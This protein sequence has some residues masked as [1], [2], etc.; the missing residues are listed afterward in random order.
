LQKKR[1]EEI[2]HILRDNFSLPSWANSN[3]DP[4]RTLILTVLSQATADRN[5]AQAFRNLQKR[6]TIT[7]E[8][9]SKAEIGDIENAI[10][11]GG[12]YRNKAKVI[13]AVS[14]IILN[15]HEGSLDFIYSLP[16]EDAREALLT[17]PGVGPKTA[18]IVLLFCA[19]KPAI[20][21]DTHV[22]RVSKRLGL[23][24]EKAGYEGVRGALESLYSPEDYLDVHLMLISHGRKFC[25][26]RKPLC[27][28]CP[29]NSLCPSRRTGDS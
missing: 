10:K 6:F 19:K 15:H 13:K 23:A 5:S 8:S 4:F 14:R 18:D 28:D 2:L 9:L 20:P 17:L 7:P 24:P 11:V 25:K 22:N 16:F 29:V 3:R 27:K 21:V 1:A 26:A 12:L